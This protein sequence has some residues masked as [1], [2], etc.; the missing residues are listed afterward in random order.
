MVGAL[1]MSHVLC[2]DTDADQWRAVA[3]AVSRFGIRLLRLESVGYSTVK[4]DLAIR[5]LPR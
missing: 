1:R 2:P 3:E 4:V 5:I